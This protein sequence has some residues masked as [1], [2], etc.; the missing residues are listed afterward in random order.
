MIDALK[1]IRRDKKG[2]SRGLTKCGF[3]LTLGVLSVFISSSGWAGN[4]GVE[5]AVYTIAEPDM[6][7]GI[8]A[9]LVSLEQSGDLERE[10]QAVIRRSVA[11]MLRP[12]AVAGVR[13]LEKGDTPSTRVFDPSMVLNK[14]IKNQNGYVVAHKGEHINPL[15]SMH[16]RE[17][18]VFINGDNPAQMTWANQ[19]IDQSRASKERLKIILVRGDIKASSNGLKHRVYF[20]QHGSLCRH[21]H[22]THTPTRVFQPKEGKK[23]QQKTLLVQEVKID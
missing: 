10:K 23:Q 19:V 13:D 20:D 21:F 9:K 15:D 12:Q 16:F 4:L 5:G 8:Q 18:L 2:N 14:D 17:M 1:K 6:L 3:F 11:H 7:T 22:I